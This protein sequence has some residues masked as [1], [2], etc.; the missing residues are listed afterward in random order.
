MPQEGAKD[1]KIELEYSKIKALQE[2]KNRSQTFY[3]RHLQLLQR[4]AELEMC[5]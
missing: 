3:D 1:T 5:P 2:E 4:W